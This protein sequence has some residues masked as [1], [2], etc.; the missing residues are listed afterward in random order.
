MSIDDSALHVLWTKAVGTDGY[1]KS[2][3]KAL[4]KDFHRLAAELGAMTHARDEACDA[5]KFI[6]DSFPAVREW[7]GV[8]YFELRGPHAGN[9]GHDALIAAR[10]ERDAL[11]RELAE[12]YPIAMLARRIAETDWSDAEKLALVE[13]RQLIDNHAKQTEAAKLEYLPT[14]LR[15]DQ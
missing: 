10:V 1:D 3:W 13:L 15:G 7:C 8:K 11:R 14:R 2:Q 12:Q 4:E 5:L 9:R 6:S